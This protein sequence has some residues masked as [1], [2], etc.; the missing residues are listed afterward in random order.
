MRLRPSANTDAARL[1]L[2][3]LVILAF[4]LRLY[5]LDYQSLWRD[6]V[7]AILFAR[8]EL[9]GIFPLFVVPGHNGP[10]YYTILH[11]W[12]R[13][14]GDSEFAARF[15]S[16]ICGVI[17]VP[18]IFKLGEWWIGLRGSRLAALLCATSPYLIWYSQETKM[19]GLLF[20]LSMLSTHV[21]LLALDRNRIYHWLFYLASVVVSMYVHLLA[22]LIIPFHILLF[23]VTWPRYRQ[24]VKP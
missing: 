17:A 23:L 24:A 1:L 13:L 12:I 7:D 4:A 22:V 6:E 2:L 18:L 14:A 15:F 3:S 8:R 9:T 16:L 5:Q 10:L 19:Y 20:L 11:F 21:Y